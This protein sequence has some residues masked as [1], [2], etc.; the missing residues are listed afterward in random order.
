MEDFSGDVKK[1]SQ[2]RT[3][4]INILSDLKVDLFILRKKVKI[5]CFERGKQNLTIF[6]SVIKLA[7]IKTEVFNMEFK[8]V[9]NSPEEVKE[10][11]KA[12]SQC[13]AEID[14]RADPFILMPSLC[15]V[16]SAWE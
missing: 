1:M 11:V 10:F 7:K 13:D 6:F 5:A 12:A 2:I 16:C 9:L 15:L 14:L 8:V 4:E 3:Y